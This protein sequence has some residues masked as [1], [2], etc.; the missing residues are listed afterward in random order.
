MPWKDALSEPGLAWSSAAEFHSYSSPAI[1]PAGLLWLAAVRHETVSG[2][3][4]QVLL[5]RQAKQ[6]LKYIWNTQ[7][8]F[9]AHT[10]MGLV[11]GKRQWVTTRSLVESQSKELN[12]L[13][14][15]WKSF[16]INCSSEMLLQFLFLFSAVKTSSSKIMVT[17]L[18][19]A[20][21]LISNASRVFPEIQTFT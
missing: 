15:F 17:S 14:V 20:Y 19:Q 6:Y 8:R 7:L 9:L 12:S 3:E 18:L 11:K 16:W 21:I 13:N 2:I 5:L 10:S 1:I 4:R